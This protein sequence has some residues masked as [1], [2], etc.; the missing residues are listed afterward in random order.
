MKT[1]RLLLW[2]VYFLC[3]SIIFISC[4]DDEILQ[5]PKLQG[6]SAIAGEGQ[7]TI[8]WNNSQSAMSY[9]IYWS[10][11]AGFTTE[12]GTLISN[13]VSPYTHTGRTFGAT[14]YYIVT[15]VNGAG[16][17]PASDEVSATLSP[18]A[19]LNVFVSTSDDKIT[20]SW[21]EVSGAKSYNIYW[22]E[23]PGVT[24]AMLN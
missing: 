18:L 23:S 21:G 10:E 15:A 16:E 22:A 11:S 13:I 19:P 7:V 17:G 1:Y 2:I 12:N 20:I 3:I 14:Y 6:V 24:P 9:N 4:K 5:L 8:S